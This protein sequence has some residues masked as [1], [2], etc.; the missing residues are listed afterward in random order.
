L[1]GTTRYGNDIV[2]IWKIAEICALANARPHTSIGGVSLLV[3]SNQ[4]ETDILSR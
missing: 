1:G 3:G 2:G 4:R